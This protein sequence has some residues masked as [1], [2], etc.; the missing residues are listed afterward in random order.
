[1]DG[2]G[3]LARVFGMS[4][5]V[6]R[7]HA[8]P[9]SGWSRAL[10]GLP[11][12]CLSIWSRAWIGS[13]AWAALG[14]VALWLWLNPRVF[15]PPPRFDSWM[16]RGVMGEKVY[17]AHRA[18]LPAHHRRAAALL[19]WLSLPGLLVMSWGLYVLAADLVILGAALAALPK[20]WFIDRMVWILED[21]QRA[22]GTVWQAG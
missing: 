11:L 2:M 7:R 3:G 17:L 19:A 13:W 21:W 5:T 15:P 6:W 4:E 16:S 8:N 18:A 10:T 9:W 12:I 20:F 1:M 14:L 22:G